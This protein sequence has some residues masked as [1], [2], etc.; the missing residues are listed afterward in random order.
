MNRTHSKKEFPVRVENETDFKW[1]YQ[2]EYLIY[3]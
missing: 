2:P 1:I 3:E